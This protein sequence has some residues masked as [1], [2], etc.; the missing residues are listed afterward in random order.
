MPAMVASAKT[1]V[2]TLDQFCCIMEISPLS[3]AVTPVNVKVLIPIA[4]KARITRGPAS[5]RSQ[6][7]RAIKATYLFLSVIAT[8]QHFKSYLLATLKLVGSLFGSVVYAW[9]QTLDGAKNFTRGSDFAGSVTL[10][11]AGGMGSSWR[12]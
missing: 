6:G 7:A 9:A 3:A 8:T 1:S 12:R 4:I 11:K 5:A 10:L 2:P